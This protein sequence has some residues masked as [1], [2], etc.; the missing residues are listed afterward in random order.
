[1]KTKVRKMKDEIYRGKHPIYGQVAGY[2][3]GNSFIAHQ[4]TTSGSFFDR[5]VWANE[6]FKISAEIDESAEW[7]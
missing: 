5:G 7:Y 3:E 1:M 2:F 6:G 4:T